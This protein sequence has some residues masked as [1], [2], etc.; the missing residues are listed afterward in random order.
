MGEQPTKRRVKVLEPK[1]KHILHVVFGYWKYLC[2]PKLRLWQDQSVISGKHTGSP[3]NFEWLSWKEMQKLLTC[4]GGVCQEVFWQ[5]GVRHSWT[6][7][8]FKSQNNTA[9]PPRIPV[10]VT[11]NALLQKASVTIQQSQPNTSAVKQQVVTLWLTRV[12]FIFIKTNVLTSA[13][14]MCVLSTRV[15]VLFFPAW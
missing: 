10:S 6:S 8:Y 1:K 5:I 4:F 7:A 15:L 13:L 11:H 14:C 9:V 12:S 2:Y 3:D